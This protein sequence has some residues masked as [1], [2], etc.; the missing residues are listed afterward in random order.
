[1]M[2]LV[3]NSKLQ[4]VHSSL[5]NK[6]IL[7]KRICSLTDC[8]VLATID[9]LV[10]HLWSCGL[11]DNFLVGTTWFTHKRFSGRILKF[12]FMFKSSLCNIYCILN[13][14]HQCIPKF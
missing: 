3:V 2:T 14:M 10:T 7:Y 8:Y 9:F 6:P 12:L 1:M 5:K 11:S 4:H 13:T